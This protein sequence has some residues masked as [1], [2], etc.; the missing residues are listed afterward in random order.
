MTNTYITTNTINAGAGFTF[1]ASGDSLVVLPGVTLGST[2]SAAINF[3]VLADIEVTI[4]GTLVGPAMLTLNPDSGFTI[5]L[6]GTMVSQE[7]FSGNAGLYLL[8]GTSQVNIDGTLLATETVGILAGLGGNVITVTGSVTGG[9]NGVWLGLGGGT[10]NV[11]VNSGT[12]RCG[13][14]ADVTRDTLFNNGVVAQSANTRITNLA[15]GEI[16][17]TSS[18]G[19]GVR[20]VTGSTGSVV[21]NEGTISASVWYGVD[22][23]LLGAIESGRLYNSGVI[24]GLQGAFNGNDTADSVTNRGTMIGDV[25]M[26]DGADRLDGRGGSFYGQVFGDAGDDRLDFRGAGLLADTVHGGVGNDTIL[27]TEGDDTISGDLDDDDLSG[28]GGNDVLSGGAGFDNVRGGAGDD[29]IDGGS[30]FSF[31]YGGE[32]D[33]TI[34]IVIDGLDPSTYAAAFGGGGDD[35]I[36]GGLFADQLYGG[37]GNDNIYAFDGGDFVLGGA[38][39]D[40]L[41][42]SF[43][44]DSGAGG[45]GDDTIIGEQGFDS[46][47]GNAGADS[48]DG[49]TENDTLNGGEGNDSLYGGANND[50]LT[51]GIG[52]DLLDGGN[53]RDSLFGGG[54]NDTLVGGQHFDTMAGGQ[55]SDVFVFSLVTHIGTAAGNRDVITDFRAGI[56]IIDLTDIDAN[57]TLAANQAFVFIG[58]GAF[59]SVA[60][61]LRYSS[62]DGLLQGDADGNG[63]A[64]FSLELATRPALTVL[65]ILL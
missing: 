59:T 43:G 49:G 1:A 18:E 11:L 30:G 28:G 22:F 23:T 9:S 61:Q 3:G 54:G 51:G 34:L 42:L 10:G 14:Y 52:D 63:V 19:A 12:I 37:D 6:G 29:R 16:I 62:V 32:G 17:A 56:D 35:F 65:D 45:Q 64:D 25:L 55:G 15:G 2:G 60:G 53:D 31:L 27:G 33:D 36:Q 5:G 57:T 39:D 50:R 40:L 41:S 47:D 7:A 48:L 8:G 26:G 24:R 20:L 13:T 46:L 44:D 58:A 38:G 21:W 4:L